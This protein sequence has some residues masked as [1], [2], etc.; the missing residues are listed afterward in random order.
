MDR[1][2]SSL[3]RL[4]RLSHP[5]TSVFFRCFSAIFPQISPDSLSLHRRRMIIGFTITALIHVILQRK[6][7]RSIINE[8]AHGNT[9][10][11]VLLRSARYQ[12]D[13]GKHRTNSLL[14]YY[15]CCRLVADFAEICDAVPTVLCH[16]RPTCASCLLLS[17]PVLFWKGAQHRIRVHSSTADITN[18]KGY[19]G[20]RQKSHQAIRVL[21]PPFIFC[22]FYFIFF[23]SS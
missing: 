13:W 8:I 12:G 23:I 21:F 11:S 14:P 4:L 22:L 5:V 2:G 1:L 16:A 9:L 15:M 6:W 18:L 10:I 20:T 7:R 19:C 17:L 3:P